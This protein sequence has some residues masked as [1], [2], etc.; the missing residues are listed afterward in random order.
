MLATGLPAQESEEIVRIL[1]RFNTCTALFDFESSTL[2]FIHVSP[3]CTD[4]ITE[5]TLS[6]VQLRD[7]IHAAD[8]AT[9][10]MSVEHGYMVGSKINLNELNHLNFCT[11]VR[12]ISSGKKSFTVLIVLKM[13]VG[14]QKGRCPAAVVN[15]HC[16]EPSAHWFR[17]SYAIVNTTKRCCIAQYSFTKTTERENTVLKCSYYNRQVAEMA[18]LMEITE[19][20]VHQHIRR[21]RNK[22]GMESLINI[23]YRNI[24]MGLAKLLLLLT[25]EDCMVLIPA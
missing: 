22:C 1:K 18:D 4:I 9:Y 25:S 15:F 11:M 10:D 2:T 17:A 13:L 19:S 7:R 16:Y 6:A 12:M 23:Y 20:G 5:Q 8:R 3:D 24:H 14:A 21:I